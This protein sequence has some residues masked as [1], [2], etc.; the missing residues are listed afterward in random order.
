MA[1]LH[2]PCACTAPRDLILRGRGFGNNGA[3]VW[4][5]ACLGPVTLDPLADFDPAELEAWA[6]VSAGVHSIWF[7]TPDILEGWALD[8]LRKPDSELNRKGRELGRR[9]SAGAGVPV[10]YYVFV[11]REHVS[12]R[13]PGC[14]ATA[15]RS[16][17]NPPQLRCRDCSM[18]F[19]GPQMG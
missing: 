13:C 6:A 10:W 7:H 1:I 3:V 19:I 17:W 9:I 12:P 2:E 4:C 11:E 8:Q 15:E 16:P 5:G 14:G 18:C